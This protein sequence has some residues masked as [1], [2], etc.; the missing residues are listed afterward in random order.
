MESLST[1]VGGRRRR[2]RR[3]NRRSRKHS[4]RHSRKHGGSCPLQQSAGKRRRRRHSRR[5][6]R[7]SGGASECFSLNA[8]PVS[9]GKRRR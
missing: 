2:S 9:G 1:M 8:A 6:L 4:R 5:H 3:S 7:K